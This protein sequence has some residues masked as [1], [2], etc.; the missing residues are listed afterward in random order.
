MTDASAW[1]SGMKVQGFSACIYNM[2][3]IV[4]HIVLA[5]C[6]LKGQNPR[7]RRVQANAPVCIAD[8][9]AWAFAIRSFRN[10]SGCM[11]LKHQHE[12]CYSAVSEFQHTWISTVLTVMLKTSQPGRVG[13]ASHTPST[14]AGKCNLTL[15][16]LLLLLGLWLVLQL[17]LCWFSLLLLP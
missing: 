12:V 8:A 14:C 1:T 13:L 6:S 3:W 17:L 10:I 16:C 2:P 11:R 15:L 9:F 5:T 4:S 7:W